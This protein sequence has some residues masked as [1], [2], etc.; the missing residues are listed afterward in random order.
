VHDD[1]IPLAGEA[2]EGI[3]LG[4]IDIFARRFVGEG[5][6]HRD[7]FKLAIRVLVEGADPDV[8]DALPFHTITVIASRR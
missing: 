8:A 7:L 2:Q 5:A 6:V 4:T 1:R 3:Q